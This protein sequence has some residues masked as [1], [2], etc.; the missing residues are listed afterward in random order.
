MKMFLVVVAGLVFTIALIGIM[1]EAG[2]EKTNPSTGCVSWTDFT[3]YGEIK[4]KPGM[5]CTINKA[6]ENTQEISCCPRTP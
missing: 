4:L 1:V 6:G 5:D 3:H 2:K